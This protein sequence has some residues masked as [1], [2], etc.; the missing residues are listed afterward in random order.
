MMYRPI[1][2]KICRLVEN[3]LREGGHADTVISYLYYYG[4]NTYLESLVLYRNLQLPLTD[5]HCTGDS[6]LRNNPAPRSDN[7]HHVAGY[8][9]S[10]LT[11]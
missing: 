3:M 6:L 8:I 9:Y 4:T 10:T 11:S 7:T 5:I 1:F 2:T